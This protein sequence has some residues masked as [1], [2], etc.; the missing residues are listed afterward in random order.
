MLPLAP[1][2]PLALLLCRRGL[3]PL[4]LAAG[5]AAGPVMGF[6]VP[7]R[8]FADRPP[9]GAVPMR[10]VTFNVGGVA[11]SAGLVEFLRNARADVFA[12]QEWPQQRAFPEGIAGEWHTARRGELFVA[13][14]FPIL[15]IAAARHGTVRKNAPAI[16]CDIKTPAGIVH[17]HC[18]HLYTLRKGLD[19]VIS[20][21]W[22]GAPELERVAAVR[23]EESEIAGHFA[24]ECDGPAVV[25]GD[26]N[27]PT[28]SVIFRRDWGGWQD[29]FSVRGFGFGYSFASRRIALRIDHVLTEARHWQ[30]QSCD[31]GPDLAGQ[32][33]PVVAELLLLE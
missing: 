25:L 22:K 9:Q 11:D 23:N 5:C 19:A 10:V 14:R 3:V 13:S 26:F 7:W 29:A 30:V 8:A 27:M 32:H 31:V 18:L 15:D 28:D 12:F 4:L 33:R 20:Q 6:N 2:V 1:L 24:G 17:L 16:R 21:K